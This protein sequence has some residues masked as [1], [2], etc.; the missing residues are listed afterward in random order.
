MAGARMWH[1]PLE[2]F[3]PSD[4]DASGDPAYYGFIDAEGVYYILQHNVASGTMRYHADTDTSYTYTNAWTNRA[5]LTYYR[6]D[7]VMPA[8][9]K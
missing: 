8:I 1:S 6:F 2:R 4:E 5:S 3:M 7:Q 9:L